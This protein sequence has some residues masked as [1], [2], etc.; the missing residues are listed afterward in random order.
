MTYKVVNRFSYSNN[1]KDDKIV[2]V[3][4]FKSKAT[5]ELFHFNKLKKS[6]GILSSKKQFVICK[7]HPQAFFPLTVQIRTKKKN[8][9]YYCFQGYYGFY[10]FY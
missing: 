2:I 5:Y 7:K 6:L 1:K 8:I 4:L 9:D 10:K 3:T